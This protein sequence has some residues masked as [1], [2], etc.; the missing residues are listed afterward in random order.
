[1]S[2]QA[3]NVGAGQ[4]WAVREF[5]ALMAAAGRPDLEPVIPGE[6]RFGDTRHILSDISK[7][8]ALGWTPQGHPAQS[9]REYIEWAPDFGNYTE[10]ARAHMRQVGAKGCGTLSAAFPRTCGV[11][12]G[13]H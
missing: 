11:D 2:Y 5:A 4:A 12:H 8:R 7:L 3:F 1:M 13:L 9:A 10:A 6:Y